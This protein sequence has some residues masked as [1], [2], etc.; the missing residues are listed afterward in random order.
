MKKFLVALLVLATVACGK[1]GDPRPPIPVI[2][3][4]TSDLVVTQRGN[5]VILAWS[6]PGLTTAGRSLTDIKTISIHRYEESLPV[7]PGGRDPE[8]LMPGD[9]DPDQPLPIVLFSKVPTIAQAQFAKLNTRIQS[10]E[11]ANLG[12]ASAGSRL[13]FT[14]TPAFLSTDGRPVRITYAVVTEGTSAR[15]QFSNLAMII[16]LPVGAAPKLAGTAQP[17]GIKLTWNAPAT[18]AGD[19]AAPVV[20]GY[21]VYRTEP[22]VVPGDLDTPLNPAPVKE[23][24]FTDAPSY[25]EHEYRVAAVAATGPPLVQG[26]LSEP[27]RIDFRDRVAPPVPASVT[28]L[29]EQRA[30]RLIWD[31]VEAP[32]LAGYR[33]YRS[34]GVG[35]GNAIKDIGTIQ[36]GNEVTATSFLD[37]SANLGIAYRYSVTAVD[38][39]G[40]ESARAFTDWVVA[41]KTP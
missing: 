20:S 22:G 16:P 32:D 36:L 28:P 12:S 25:G 8:T 37:L 14:D 11:K 34:E 40:N 39:S 35:H 27:L 6:Y 9:V 24:T 29:I 4:A 26:E 7:S 1:R 38:K 13:F 23:T 10:I 15:S 31:P 21:N 30:V 5:R 33:V 3:Q 2:P 19:A 17:E 18:T 41:P